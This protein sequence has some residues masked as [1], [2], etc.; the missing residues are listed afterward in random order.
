MKAFGLVFGKKAGVEAEGTRGTKDEA[1]VESERG[2][3]VGVTA[4]EASLASVLRDS[5]EDSSPVSVVSR[6][7]EKEEAEGRALLG[8]M[9]TGAAGMVPSITPGSRQST[10]SARMWG[11]RQSSLETK[12]GSHRS[13]LN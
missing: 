12:T 7:L 5:M 10:P 13:E 1:S 11:K 4:K 3:E 6:S 2:E 8:M 9:E